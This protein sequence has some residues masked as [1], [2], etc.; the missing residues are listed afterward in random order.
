MLLEEHEPEIA[1]A[2]LEGAEEFLENVSRVQHLEAR[3]EVEFVVVERVE[4][5]RVAFDYEGF[6]SCVVTD[7]IDG[8]RAEARVPVGING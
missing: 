7:E 1:L 6:V 2:L 5:E 3:A 8:S 4:E